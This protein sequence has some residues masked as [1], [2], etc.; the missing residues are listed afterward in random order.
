[1]LSQ[2]SIISFRDTESQHEKYRWHTSKMRISHSY[3]KRRAMWMA[4]YLPFLASGLHSGPAASAGE[5]HASQMEMMIGLG[6]QVPVY[7]ELTKQRG[8]DRET[9]ATATCDCVVEVEGQSEVEKVV[10]YNYK[11]WNFTHF[12]PLLIGCY[13]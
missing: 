3:F 13:P 12:I 7:S 10:L 2:V 1:M 6:L 8:G 9:V 11:V 4:H 5:P